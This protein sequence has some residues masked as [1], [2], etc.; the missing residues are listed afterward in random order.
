MSKASEE[1]LWYLKRY[2]SRGGWHQARDVTVA[3][4]R[5]FH[6]RLLKDGFLEQD[7]DN[8][9]YRITESGLNAI[10]PKP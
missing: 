2:Y 5:A 3:K 10:T 4:Y 8:D 7:V 9:L 1:R 6:N